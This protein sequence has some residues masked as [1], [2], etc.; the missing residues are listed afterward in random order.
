LIKYS[1]EST[2]ALYE[3]L[4]KKGYFEPDQDQ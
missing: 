1:I 4:A 3:A 2:E